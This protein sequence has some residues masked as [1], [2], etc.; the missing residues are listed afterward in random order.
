M[1]TYPLKNMQKRYGNSPSQSHVFAIWI[2]SKIGMMPYFYLIL[3]WTTCWLL[4]NAHGPESLGFDASP[5]FLMWLLISNMVQIFSMP[6]I[7]IGQN[8]QSR[9]AE[10]LANEDFEVIERAYLEVLALKE[11]LDYL[12]ELIERKALPAK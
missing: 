9:H 5:D 4:W 3:L 12:T 11:K 1:S 7:I 8:L 2:A 10:I 6:L